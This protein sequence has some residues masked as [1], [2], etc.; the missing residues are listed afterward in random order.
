MLPGRKMVSPVC[1]EQLLL[2]FSL[3]FR[4][5]YCLLHLVLKIPRYNW[6]PFCYLWCILKRVIGLRNLLIKGWK[7]RHREAICL[8]NKCRISSGV[9]VSHMAC[10]SSTQRRTWMTALES[11]KVFSILLKALPSYDMFHITVWFC[12]SWKCLS[13]N[14]R[15]S[16]GKTIILFHCLL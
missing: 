15:I 10:S 4:A 13:M 11:R 3:F 8:F 5:S 12:S 1:S 9:K 14:E 16:L 2:C 6:V 7:Q